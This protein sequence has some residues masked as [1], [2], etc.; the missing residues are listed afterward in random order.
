[1]PE[2]GELP[3][4]KK[5]LQKGVRDMVRISDARM[6][7]TSFGACVLHVSPEAAR[8]GPLGLGRGRRHDRARRGRRGGSTCSVRRRSWRAGG[9]PGREPPPL[10][11]P[12]L[13]RAVPQHVMQADEGCD[14]DFLTPAGETPEPKIY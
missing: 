5:L 11:L 13:R 1:M 12:R 4:P 2:W 9:P 6:S 14:F 10:L 3:I 8:G 7:G